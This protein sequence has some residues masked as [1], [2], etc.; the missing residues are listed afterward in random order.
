MPKPAASEVFFQGEKPRTPCPHVFVAQTKARRS[1]NENSN[2]FHIH[3]RRHV[4]VVDSFI[5]SPKVDGRPESR[6]LDDRVHKHSQKR[7]KAW[8]PNVFIALVPHSHLNEYICT[9]RQPSMMDA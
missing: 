1:L 2:A 5:A 8:V 3:S 7:I 6:F 4:A 9:F